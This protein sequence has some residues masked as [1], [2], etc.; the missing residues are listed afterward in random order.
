MHSF[1]QISETEFP[2][3]QMALELLPIK[4][5]DH[6]EGDSQYTIRLSKL[7][8]ALYLTTEFLEILKKDQSPVME[9]VSF[10]ER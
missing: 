8:A 1:Q 4:E 6:S 5:N 9:N 7:S 3:K 10:K 2:A